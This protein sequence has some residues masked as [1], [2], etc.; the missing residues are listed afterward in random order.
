[1]DTWGRANKLELGKPTI[2]PLKTTREVETRHLQFLN[3]KDRE[4]GNRSK[5]EGGKQDSERKSSGEYLSAFSRLQVGQS[6]TTTKTSI[7]KFVTEE[8][9]VSQAM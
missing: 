7:I 9:N 8:R 5:D 2:L 4:S 6:T 1:M 3:I